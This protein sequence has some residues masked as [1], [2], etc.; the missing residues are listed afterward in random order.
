MKQTLTYQ[1]FSGRNQAISRLGGLEDLYIKYVERFQSNYSN[2]AAELHRLINIENYEEAKILVHSVKGL[3]AT[4]GMEDL[5]ACAGS[6]ESAIA[7]GRFID[8]P[9]LFH[10]YERALIQILQSDIDQSSSGAGTV[11]SGLK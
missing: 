9:S 11:F 7:E 5:Q 2:S 3:A 4:L 1:P 8:L 10:Y 6:I